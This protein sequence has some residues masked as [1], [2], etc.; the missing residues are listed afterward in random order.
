M[1][2]I[3]AIALAAMLMLA[4]LPAASAATDE[5][6]VRATVS[7]LGII[8]GDGSGDLKL[9]NNVTRAEFVRM[10]VAASIY[11]G[12]VGGGAKT[13]PF[14]D[15]KASHWAA[16]YIKT[17]VNAGWVS[18]YTDGTFRPNRTVTLDEAAAALMNLLGYTKDDIK[19]SYPTA[20]IAKFRSLELDE[21]LSLSQGQ[22]LTRRD[23]MYIFYNLMG[24]K[25]KSGI[26]YGV[27][28][29][30]TLNSDG[31]IDYDKLVEDETKGP[32]VVYGTFST[33]FDGSPQF[34]Y[35]D[36]KLTNVSAIEQYDVYYYNAMSKTIW[37]Y[38]DKAMGMYTAAA[39]NQNDPTSATVGGKSYTLSG[40]DARTKLSKQGT[41][42]Y[43][44]TVILLLDKNGAA[45][46][47][48]APGKSE[49]VYYG[50]VTKVDYKSYESGS[51]TVYGYFTSVLCTD[52]VEREFV[53]AQKSVNEGKLALAGIQGGSVVAKT[54]QPSSLSGTVSAD[55]TQL[56][57]YKFASGAEIL[58]YADS[59]RYTF[60]Y[61]SRLAGATLQEKD[62]RFY[63]L[64]GRGEIS[65]LILNDATGDLNDYVVLTSVSEQN[66]VQ[67]F[68]GVYEYVKDGVSGRYTST[69]ELFGVGEGPVMLIWMNSARVDKIKPLEEAGL[70]LVSETRAVAGAKEYLLYD[71]VQVYIKKDDA[72]Y[73]VEIGAVTDP[74]KYTVTGWYDGNGYAAGGRLRIIIAVEKK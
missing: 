10:M 13:S 2:R 3:C 27:T 58:D 40:K 48:I 19:G 12:S 57:K 4:A 24:A 43:G 38:S 30:Y 62:V 54:L 28:L 20:Q 73:L 21:G 15:V 65:H 56:G 31:K 68:N 6:T 23:C 61:P 69:Y 64:N 33:P 29:G 53:T 26:A 52:G 14:S 45:V 37:A 36:G 7:A 35:R 47:V 17:A 50:V 44:D 32:F 11:E 60:I 5:G 67:Y 42:S 39:P 66:G 72:Y 34:V 70:D 55:A 63:A 41:F 51:G 25:G 74:A 46:D 59:G 16:E 71:D 18:G 9:S 49:I 8:N 1:K 22:E